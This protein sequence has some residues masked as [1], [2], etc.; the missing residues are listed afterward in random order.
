[1][2]LTSTSLQ[3]STIVVAVL[4]TVA[5][6]LLW[7]RVRGPRPVRAMT[8]VLLLSSGYA[9]T[10]VA[11]LVSVNIAYGGLIVSVS[12]LFSNINPPQ[13]THFGHPGRHPGGGFETYGG[14]APGALHPTATA[15]TTATAK[16]GPSASHA[17]N[18]P[19]IGKNS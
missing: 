1:M 16:V 9:T 13:G 3:V 18:I 11:V 5:V 17:S 7:N 14:G 12:D 8:R 19:A 15:T 4:A 6:L 2:L 10:A